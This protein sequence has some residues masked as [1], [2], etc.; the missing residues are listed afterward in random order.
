MRYLQPLSL[1]AVLLGSACDARAQQHEVGHWIGLY[2][3]GP[4]AVR[5]GDEDVAF[6]A[7][8]HVCPNHHAAGFVEFAPANGDAL[9]LLPVWGDVNPRSRALV[10]ILIIPSDDPVRPDDLVAAIVQPSLS[11]PDSLS[12]DIALPIGLESPPVFSAAGRIDLTRDT[13]R[14]EPVDFGQFRGAALI[15]TP[16]QDVETG[17]V[18]GITAFEARLGISPANTSTGY[19]NI[20][21]RGGAV[22]YE[23]VFGAGMPDGQGGVVF[24]IFLLHAERE[25]PLSID[26]HLLR[27]IV[28]P[29]GD[30]DD[31]LLWS[32]RPGTSINSVRQEMLNNKYP[33]NMPHRG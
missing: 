18:T 32:L 8:I 4:Q 12:W 21:T 33:E 23:G 2:H 17:E 16:L 25:G 31:V 28:R 10:V 5:L 3:S 13:G 19:L 27:A 30:G 24:V 22:P 29:V 15:E 20:H 26:D 7:E 11:D 9:R 1:L 6:E 14:C